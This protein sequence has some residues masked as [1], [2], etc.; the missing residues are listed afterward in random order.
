QDQQEH[1]DGKGQGTDQRDGLQGCQT[2]G[3]QEQGGSGAFQRAPVNA[4]PDWSVF[5]PTGGQG[6][7]NQRAR[8]GR[9]HKENGYQNNCQGRGYIGPRQVF[10]ELEQGHG[11]I[12][13]SIL[14]QL[15]CRHTH[16]QEDGGVTKNG[17]PEEGE[18][19]GHQQDAQY[20]LTHGAATRDAGD[21]HADKGRPR[22]PPG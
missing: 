1:D 19:G 5:H 4:L 3:Q 18:D 14:G 17:H 12:R 11:C 20:E 7:D 13:G 6:I 15:A 21:E 2:T 9:G 10:Q 8:V 16:I 22:D